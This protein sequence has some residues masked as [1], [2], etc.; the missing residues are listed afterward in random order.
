MWKETPEGVMIPIKVVPKASRSEIVGWE[1]EELK[2]RLAAVP[3]KGEANE[4]LLRFLAKF[5]GVPK[6]A[7]KLIKGETS[8][9]KTVK[10]EAELNKIQEKLHAW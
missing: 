1:N 4:E 8:R 10:I 7:V 9:H 2:V 6:G 5:F 3:E